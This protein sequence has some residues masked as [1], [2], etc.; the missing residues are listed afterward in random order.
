MRAQTK[1]R[2]KKK[3]K[4][5]FCLKRCEHYFADMLEQG[6]LWFYLFTPYFCT[7]VC[8]WL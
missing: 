1:N 7:D 5:L 3:S 8:M 6:P 4:E 2:R